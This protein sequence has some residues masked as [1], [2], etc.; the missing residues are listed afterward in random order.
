MKRRSFITTIGTGASVFLAGAGPT[1]MDPNSMEPYVYPSPDQFDDVLNQKGEFMLRL[2]VKAVDSLEPARVVMEFH[3]PRGNIGK[4]RDF[5][6]ANESAIV[7]QENSRFELKVGKA[8]PYIFAFWLNEPRPSTLFSFSFNGNVEQFTLAQLLDEQELSFQQQGISVSC[9]YLLDKE[10]GK[11]NLEKIGISGATDSFSI[12]ILADP[13]GGNPV[14]PKAHP[15][16]MKIHNAFIEDSVNRINDLNPSPVLSLV[17]GDIVDNQGEKSHFK[18]MH[19]YLKKIQTPILYAVGNHETRYQATFKP[20]YHMAEFNH[21]FSAQKA[22][23]GM[24][25]LLYSFDLGDWHFI[26]WPDPLRADFFETHPHYF[27]WLEEDLHE[28]RDKPTVFLQHVPA[29]P[30]GIDPLINYAESVAVKRMVLDRLATHGN[31]RFIF[32][33]HVNIPIKASFKTAVSYKGMKMINLPAAGYRPR[34]FG[35]EE[36][37]GGPSQGVLIFEIQGKEAKA[38]FKTVTEE[39]YPYPEELPEFNESAYPLWLNYKWQLDADEEI[40]NGNFAQGLSHWHPRFVYREDDHPSNRMEVKRFQGYQALY[41]RSEK[42]KYHI[43]GQD[44][45]PQTINHVCQGLLLDAAPKM[46]ALDYCL[47]KQSVNLTNAWAGGYIWLEG[48]QGSVKLLN[49]AYW[50]GKGT[51]QLID[52]FTDQKEIPFLH[53][54]LDD[55]MEH[56][57]QVQLNWFSDYQHQGLDISQLDRLVINLGTWHVNDGNS[58][59]FGIYFSQVRVPKQVREST[60]NQRRIKPMPDEKMWWMNKY[61]P[62]VH[63]A[64]EH[65]YIMSTG[66]KH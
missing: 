40:K 24:E 55:Q 43:P 41:L 22:M 37:H 5:P 23:N 31:V 39:V 61:E 16:R 46:I 44:R 8:F 33:G 15:T 21:Y 60:V 13:Q 14:T 66:K 38:Y 19:D 11:L 59:G 18:A 58:P 4:V 36:L 57:Q 64:G 25:W 26:V 54:Q 17:L 65:R 10:I 42:R 27:D 35:E 29:H 9:N 30:I 12:A 52:R 48:F 45:L 49:M 1:Q 63:I 28:N 7:D 51:S 56:W 3:I 20:G 50:V 47:D 32:S 53:F 6:F 34:A 62:F 2:E